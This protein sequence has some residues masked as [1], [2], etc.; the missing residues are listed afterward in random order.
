M[1]LGGTASTYIFGEGKVTST[2]LTVYTNGIRDP[3]DIFFAEFK[4]Y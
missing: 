3:V 4:I 2:D 1:I